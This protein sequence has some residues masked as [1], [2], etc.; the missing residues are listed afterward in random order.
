VCIR[1]EI[2]FLKRL[3]RDEYP[4]TDRL[5]EYLANLAAEG[6]RENR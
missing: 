4:G 3:P 1:D 6:V 2:A 5:I